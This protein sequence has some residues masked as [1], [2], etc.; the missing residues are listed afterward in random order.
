MGEGMNGG[1]EEWREEAK[2]GKKEERKWWEK[3]EDK[4]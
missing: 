3:E 4:Q 2:E 1:V